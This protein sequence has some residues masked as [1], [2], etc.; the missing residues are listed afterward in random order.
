MNAIKLANVIK[1]FADGGDSERPGTSQRG[2]CRYADISLKL[3]DGELG[4]LFRPP[5]T[6]IAEVKRATPN[7]QML[8]TWQ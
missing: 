5:Y 1:T 6:L 8:C 7:V 2:A 4:W 3:L